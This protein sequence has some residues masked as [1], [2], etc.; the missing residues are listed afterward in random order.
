MEN[1]PDVLPI[2]PIGGGA[3]RVPFDPDE[4]I[5][6]LR[7]ERYLQNDLARERDSLVRNAYYLLRRLLPVGV[8]KHLQRYRLRDWE[9][10]AHPSWPVDA[11]VDDLCVA[12]LK[13]A[14]EA[15][16]EAQT[17]FIWFWPEGY[18]GCIMVTHDVETAR[19]RDFC[20][21]L[22]DIDQAHGFV[23]SFELIPEQRYSV[24]EALLDS[25]RSRGFEVCLHGLYHDGHLFRERREFL[26]RAKLIGEYARAWGAIGFRSPVMYRNPDWIV[27]LDIDY[28]MSWPSVGHLD[29]QRGGCCTVMPYLIGDI[30]E[31]PLTMT[32]DYSL[33]HILRSRDIRLWQDQAERIFSRFGL[34]SCIVH[35]D[36][37]TG[38]QELAVY[39]DLL[40]FLERCRLERHLWTALPRD[41]AHW[42]RLRRDMR[43]VREDAA[44]KI[45][46]IGSERARLAWAVIDGGNVRYVIEEEDSSS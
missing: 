34:A 41:I 17:P 45:E 26:R 9:T 28:D 19:G 7:L 6:N 33:F 31:L 18:R 10:L 37:I 46:G 32:Q 21:K 24:S 43:L 3:P 8:R 29:P 14:M 20:V 13:D 22:M 15:S 44:W 39:Q 30:V 1:A 2:S 5:S 12:L 23:S 38:T 36:Y 40:E 11:S 27:D 25:I 4:V 35:P 42:C 16:G